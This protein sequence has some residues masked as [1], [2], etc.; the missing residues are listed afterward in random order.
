MRQ[1]Y[2]KL[3]EAYKL[4][5]DPETRLKVNPIKCVL[6]HDYV[7]GVVTCATNI[8][9][10][11]VD[12][13]FLLKTICSDDVEGKRSECIMYRTPNRTKLLMD[14]NITPIRCGLMAALACEKFY[15]MS[16][17]PR[18]GFI[19]TGEI[20]LQTCRTLKKLFG[21]DDIVIWGTRNHAKFREICKNVVVDWY[22]EH[23]NECDIIIT[24]TTA[25][26]S[27]DQIGFNELSKPKL[28]ISQ[29]GGYLLGESFRRYT[30]CYSDH[31]EQ[32]MKHYEDEF[33]HD[34]ERVPMP[35]MSEPSRAYPISVYLYGTALADL[36]V[37]EE[38]INAESNK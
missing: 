37:T 19:G 34:E 14:E 24:C 9:Y 33:P 28:F 29:D 23:L 21:I 25:Y 2:E 10:A 5:E 32:I 1:T 13:R 18:V 26:S 11:N 22:F 6:N 31:E 17:S 35:T 7:D 3:K 27:Y 16:S 4:I 30:T 12:K 8:M 38:W 15:D 36:I 20:N